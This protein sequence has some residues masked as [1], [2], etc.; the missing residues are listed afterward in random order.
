MEKR[1]VFS[2]GEIRVEM[3][4]GGSCFILFKRVY[5]IVYGEILHIPIEHKRF[6]LQSSLGVI[7]RPTQLH[8]MCLYMCNDIQKMFL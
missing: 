1:G 4:W 7:V 6:S 2:E 5:S 3:S 8:N